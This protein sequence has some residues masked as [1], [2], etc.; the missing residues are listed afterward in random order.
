MVSN[1]RAKMFYGIN[2]L[3][4]AEH[5]STFVG[6]TKELFSDQHRHLIKPHELV[7]PEMAGQP[8]IL[9][10]GLSAIRARSIQFGHEP[11]MQQVMR[12]QA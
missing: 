3:A 9:I 2:D 5:I 12:E 8:V 4:T 10:S 7:G 1:C 11:G 6:E